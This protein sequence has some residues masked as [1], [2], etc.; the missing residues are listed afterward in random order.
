MA[1]SGG[2]AT[3][4]SG[5]AAGAGGADAGAGCIL[6]SVSSRNSAVILSSELDGTLA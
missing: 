3:R 1:T 6:A 5:G 4:G 2:G